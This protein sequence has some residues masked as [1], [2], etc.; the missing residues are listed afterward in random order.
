MSSAA[1]TTLP[2]RQLEAAAPIPPNLISNNNL[3]AGAQKNF[4]QTGGFH[5]TQFNANTINYHGEHGPQTRAQALRSTNGS[6]VRTRKDPTSAILHRALPSRSTLR[7]PT[8][9]GRAG[10]EAICREQKTCVGRP[11]RRRVG[12]VYSPQ[13]KRKADDL[14]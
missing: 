9:A 10:R 11:R 13:S 14:K 12:S 1:N 8:T 4:Q 6:I 2:L 7:P 3:G 5:N